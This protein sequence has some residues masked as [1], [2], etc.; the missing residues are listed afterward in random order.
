MTEQET[1]PLTLKEAEK[2]TG[3]SQH[4][5]RKHVHRKNIKVVMNGRLIRIPQAEI[6]RINS[7]GL[8]SLSGEE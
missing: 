1:R 2:A 7:K 4:T 8:V 5:L 3:V 6:A